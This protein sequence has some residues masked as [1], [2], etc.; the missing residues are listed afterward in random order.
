MADQLASNTSVKCAVVNVQESADG[1]WVAAHSEAEA[2][3][4]AATKFGVDESSIQL[5]QDADVLD[6]WFSSGLFPFSIFGWPD[7]TEDLQVTTLSNQT[8]SWVPRTY[9]ASAFCPKEL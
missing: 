5:E 9:S 6:T 4:K 1:A 8:N 7:N 3:A 2:R